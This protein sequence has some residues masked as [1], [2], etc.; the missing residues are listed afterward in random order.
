MKSNPRRARRAARRGAL[1][2]SAAGLLVLPTASAASQSRPT[3]G[4]ALSGGGA[5]GL[6][7]IGVL[8]VLAEIDLPV[9][10]V[11]G[12]SMGNIVGG[13]YAIG[14]SASDIE[15]ITLALDWQE[16]FSDNVPLRATGMEQKHWEGRYIGSLPLRDGRPELPSGILA[17]QNVGRLLSRL[18][19]PAQNLARFDQ[20]PIP[21]AC[22]ATDLV[23]GAAVR[24]TSGN[25]ADAMQASGALPTL[26]MPTEIAGQLLVDGGIV[27]NFPVEDARAIGADI[28]IGV[29]VGAPLLEANEIHT[30]LDVMEQA[31][32]FEAA[33]S[34]EEQ[35]QLTDILIEPDIEGL[36][37]LD[38]DQIPETIQRGE[39]AARA[40]LPALHALKDSLDRIAPPAPGSI[41]ARPDSFYVTAL[42]VEGSGRIS[43]GVAISAAGVT[44]PEW[45]T[46]ADLDRIVDQVY[47]R[48]VFYRV[49]YR[50][51]TRGNESTLTLRV[52]E[53]ADNL[54]RFGLHF[55]T[56]TGAALLLGGLF[57]NVGIEGSLVTVDLGFGRESFL[58]TDYWFSAGLRSGFAPRTGLAG[59]FDEID[60]YEDT[61]RVGKVDSRYF[62]ASAAVGT[63]FSRLV[64][65]VAGVRAEYLDVSPDIGP[66]GSPSE[67][68]WQGVLFGSIEINTLDRVQFPSSGIW[69]GGAAEFADQSVVGH[70]SFSRAY[71]DFRGVLP[72]APRLGLLSQLFVGSASGDTIPLPYQ[73]FLGGL[74]TP[75]AF[76]YRELSRVSF[77]GLKLEE[78]RGRA[79]QF[80][81]LGAQL[82]V[83]KHGFVQLRANAG[84]TFDAWE[85]DFSSSRFESGLG[86][87]AGAATPLGPVSLSAMT[88]SRHDLLFQLD[89]GFRF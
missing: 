36:S 44:V 47:G 32:V 15:Q 16:V 85:V 8:K 81:M 43:P 61:D 33:R 77:L 1:A 83:T 37:L 73:F 72:I 40:A 78:L 70:S 86:L 6:A 54:F 21:F 29:D 41:L 24:L 14:Y 23:D 2:V 51:S 80:L 66:A 50:I 26:F 20:F 53:R 84:N 57:R 42:V 87:T 76:P 46:L 74:A 75:A 52:V 31:L 88:G 27:R 35:R 64:A 56:Q 34:T 59:S 12:T 30:F 13:L 62:A 89:L 79:A 55:D 71:L 49:G 82:E 39:Q 11:T 22:V 68:G 10:Y 65:A 48:G 63:F 5:S 4:L 9:D 7:H 18:T 28:V 60:I 19:V 17:G 45:L 69:V 58:E 67:A 3:V 38:F 25:L